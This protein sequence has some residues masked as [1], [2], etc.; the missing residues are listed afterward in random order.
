MTW[1]AVWLPELYPTRI[2]ATGVGFIF[3]VPR[4]L[5][6]AGTLM[7]GKLIVRFGGF[8]NAAVVV[9]TIY[10]L[11]LAVGPFLPETRGKSLPEAI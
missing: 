11:G 2:R 8:G 3:N 10:L 6:A 7:A 5:A 1:M 4:L 9:A